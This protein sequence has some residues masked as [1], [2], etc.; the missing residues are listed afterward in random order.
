MI[1]PVSQDDLCGRLAREQITMTQTAISKLENG[2]RYVMDYEA[3]TLAKVLKVTIS[4]L[5]GEE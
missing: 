4:W 5:Y 2:A 1:P 3:L